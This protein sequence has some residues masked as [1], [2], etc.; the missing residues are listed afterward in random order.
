MVDKYTIPYKAF[1]A[2]DDIEPTQHNADFVYIE[3][4]LNELDLADDSKVDK[5][6][7]ETLT[8]N[9]LTTALK[10]GYDDAVVKKHTHPNLT[11]LE[12]VESGGSASEFLTRAGT[13]TSVQVSN[14][15]VALGN[16][17]T[18]FTLTRD[19][20]HTANITGN[21]SLGL[22]TLSSTG[23]YVTCMIEFSISA[24]VTLTLPT[25]KWDWDFTPTF[26]TTLKNTI[27]LRTTDNG[28]IWRA[29]YIQGGT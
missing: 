23:E 8:P 27:L 6:T 12:L 7:G 14:T 21:C 19:S 2:G 9:K 16:K 15:I 18:N 29:N 17:N 4:A 28:A 5:V 22:P 24:G 11:A 10:S 3:D 20:V 1:V 13:Y 25:I 26:S